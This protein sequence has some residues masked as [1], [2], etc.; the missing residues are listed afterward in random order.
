M[1]IL[2]SR[3][4][5]TIAS[6]ISGVLLALFPM[7][8]TG[9]EARLTLPPEAED[10][11][12]QL[13]GASLI[14]SAQRDELKDAHDIVSSARAEYR[15]MLSVLYGQG[16]FGPKI[17]VLVDG[18]EAANLPP[19]ETIREVQQVELRITPGPRFKFGLTELGPLAP[20]TQITD[21]FQTGQPATTGAISQAARESVAGWRDQGHAKADIAGQSITADHKNTELDV[22][23]DLTP[24]PKL[25][26]GD[27]SISGTTRMT[28]DRL[29]EIIA[30]PVGETF[31][32]DELDRIGRRLRR[33]GV[34]RSVSISEADRIGP[35]DTLGI[36]IQ[37]EDDKPRRITFGAELESRDGLSVSGT[38]LHRNLFG[39]GERF[40]IDG[41]VSGIGAQ[42]GGTDLRLN[43]ELTR[44]A[45]FQPDT[46]LSFGLDFEMIDDPLYEMERLGAHVFLTRVISPE[47]TVAGGFLAEYS[48]S[49]DDYGDRKFQILGLPLKATWDQRDD[50]LDATS[51]YYLSGTIMPYAAFDDGA[52][53]AYVLADSRAYRRLGNGR[54][55]AAGRLQLGTI[56]GP[57]ISETPPNM[58][59]LTG[60]G[61]TVRGQP[62]QSN[63]VTVNGRESGGLSFVGISGELRV[64]TTESI[65]TVAFYD[66]GFVGESSDFSGGGNW[67][68]GA[69]LG[70]RYHTSFGPIR[71]DLGVPVSGDTSGG[72][73]LYVGIGQ[74]F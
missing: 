51:G 41:E 64:Q 20:E 21:R 30:L 44:P 32:P 48:Q 47:L 8:A 59:F 5:A 50:K 74:A 63:F 52:P 70:I 55:V 58:L 73:Q 27:L 11:R 54:V 37:V 22:E 23:I 29:R 71:V 68:A 4:R 45:T 7:M 66:A 57:S 60:G 43:T 67:H 1:G 35:D 16:Y 53:G 42:T 31:S 24:G 13:E 3:C 49:T 15:R 39:N 40:L 19:F 38:W 56:L 36:D 46:D 28:E 2:P 12:R 9:F 72:T 26:F 69:G 65:S 17:H 25:R 14:F 34:F 10:L 62:Y 6:T 61:G 18:R 33:T